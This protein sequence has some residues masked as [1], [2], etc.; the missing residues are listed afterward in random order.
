MPTVSAV[1]DGTDNVSLE[2]V[3]ASVPE[4]GSAVA[5]GNEDDAREE[6]LLRFASSLPRLRR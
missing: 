5:S 4:G 3:T 1:N 6:V 2:G